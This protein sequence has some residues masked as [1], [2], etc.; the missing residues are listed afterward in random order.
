MLLVT[1]G[2]LYGQF[3]LSLQ[4]FESLVPAKLQSANFFIY[5]KFF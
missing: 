2:N 5:I 4:D 1:I 3:V